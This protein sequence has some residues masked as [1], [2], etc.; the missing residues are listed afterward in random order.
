MTDPLFKS[1]DFR[2]L[3]LIGLLWGSSSSQMTLF[4]VVLHAHGMGDRLISEMVTAFALG[5]IISTMASGWLIARAGARAT[6]L[7]ALL[8]ALAI[9]VGLPLS[10][11]QPATIIGLNFCRGVAFGL[12]LPPGF[13]IVQGLAAEFPGSDRVRA[14][15]LFNACFL[16]P[17]LYGPALGEWAWGGWGDGWF[18]TTVLLPL[19]AATLLGLAMPPS[20]AAGGS[21]QGYLSLLLDR[22]IWPPALAMMASG[23]G[24]AFVVNFAALL[25]RPAG[26]FFAPF[27]IPLLLRLTRLER[28]PRLMLLGLGLGAYVVGFLTLLIGFPPLSGL[29]FGFAYA[30]VGPTAITWASAPYTDAAARARPVALVTL[31][32][33]LG[34]I[35]TAQLVGTVVP[36]AG[37][38]GILLLLAAIAAA[39]GLVIVIGPA[40]R[41]AEQI[42]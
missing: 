39:A 41:R 5:L 10:G 34:T 26:V 2:L 28:H 20:E 30:V 11:F 6:L 17:L 42:S 12:V 18:F 37:W 38:S 16:L 33:N 32:F 40:G 35:V 24:Y 25:V 27:A 31:A 22:R 19:L 36:F 14:V 13:V 1:R 15:G 7:L 29:A 23:T 4:A 21:A 8:S 3:L 9:T